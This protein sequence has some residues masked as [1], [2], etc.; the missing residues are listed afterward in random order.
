[1]T[2]INRRILLGL[3]PAAPAA[4]DKPLTPARDAIR[5]RYFPDIA[6]H[7]HDGKV[8]R[9]YEDLVKD[10]IVT[11][12]FMYLNCEDGSCPMTMHN[13]LR[14]QKRLGSRVGREIFMYSITLDPKRDTQAALRKYAR[15]HG[16][17]P[18]WSFLRASLEDTELLR[19]KLGFFS[20]DPEVDAKKS[21]HAAM[22]RFGNEPRQL[23][24]MV[25]GFASPEAMTRAILWVAPKTAA[26]TA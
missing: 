3:A 22:V 4:T 20:T 19:R 17:R 16:V 6:V 13:L 7:T 10:R 9:F 21:S 24:A 14:V 15:S 8:L 1:M 2:D 12:N 18:G 5:K 25:S 26:R 11:L 23:W